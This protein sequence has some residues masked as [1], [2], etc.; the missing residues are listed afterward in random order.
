MNE[1]AKAIVRA[2]GLRKDYGRGEGLV[3][4]VDEVDLDVARGETWRSWGR[5]VVASR[6]CSTCSAGW[7]GRGRAS[8]GWRAGAS[9]DFPSGSSPSFVATRSASCSRRTTLWMS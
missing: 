5:A 7:T 2:R 9:T 3:R 6:R 8:C 4:A 1:P